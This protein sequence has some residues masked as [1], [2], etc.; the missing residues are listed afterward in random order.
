MPYPLTLQQAFLT[1]PAGWKANVIVL[2]IFDR[3]DTDLKAELSDANGLL[4]AIVQ[5][6]TKQRKLNR[7]W[8]TRHGLHLNEEGKLNLARLIKDNVILN[9][10]VA[11]V[12]VGRFERCDEAE[13][14]A[15]IDAK[16]AHLSLEERAQLK[17]TLLEFGHVLDCRDNQPLG[18]TSAVKHIIRTGDVA[19]IYKKAYRVPH[20][21]SMDNCLQ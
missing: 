19:P 9:H 8:N 16:L 12:R 11:E 3:Y 15:C 5:N 18:C 4:K 10:K 17:A 20:N 1:L 14:E 6:L 7:R 2:S 13:L 21:T